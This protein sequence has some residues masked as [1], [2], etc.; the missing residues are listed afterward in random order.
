[1]TFD[2]LNNKFAC[3]CKESNSVLFFSLLNPT[4]IVVQVPDLK[5]MTCSLVAPSNCVDA[6]FNRKSASSSSLLFF[7]DQRELFGVTPANHGIEE[8]NASSPESGDS[9]QVEGSILVMGQ[10]VVV[11]KVAAAARE[12]AR[13][14]VME[15][16]RMVEAEYDVSKVATA[17][18][19]EPPSHILPSLNHLAKTFM[20]SLLLKRDPPALI[21]SKRPLKSVDKKMEIDNDS[22]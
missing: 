2:D 21:K 3:F 7:N 17:L 6:S 15:A 19:I 9:E 1:M 18:F 10:R 5:E 22:E 11:D 14:E 12:E 4:P 20:T 13:K 16:R 8:E